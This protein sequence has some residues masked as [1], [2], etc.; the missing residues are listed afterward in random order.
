MKG[1]QKVY[2]QE[3]SGEGLS[4]Y[5]STSALTEQ[6]ISWRLDIV[7]H[8]T[9]GTSWGYR[10][11]GCAQMAIAILA[12]YTGDAEFAK[13]HYMRFKEEV[14]SKKDINMPFQLK[15]T[16]IENWLKSTDWKKK[17]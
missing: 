14:I 4:V 10:G 1:K 7:A 11:S 12:H 17:E 9:T 3:K 2:Y 16:E 5:D 6:L 8:S 15:D 13:K